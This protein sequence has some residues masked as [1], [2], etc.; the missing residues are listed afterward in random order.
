MVNQSLLAGSEDSLRDLG[1]DIDGVGS[2]GQDLRLDNGDESVV[3]ADSGVSCKGVR[4]LCNSKRSGLVLCSVDVKDS[5]PLGESAALIV[6][7]LAPG[8]KSVESLGGSL[9][10]SSTDVHDSRVNLDSS[11]DVLLLEKLHEVLAFI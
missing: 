7:G 11:V 2:I 8:G 9:T 6:V 4:I 1:A 10:I 3:L 5:S